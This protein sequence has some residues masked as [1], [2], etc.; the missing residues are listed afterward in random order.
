MSKCKCYSLTL[1]RWDIYICPY[2]GR[3]LAF[4][5]RPEYK[6]PNALIER[7]KKVLNIRKPY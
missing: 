2:C 3:Q 5:P 6:E 1:P 4:L 7:I